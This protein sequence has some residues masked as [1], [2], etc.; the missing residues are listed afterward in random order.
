M[1]YTAPATLERE[2]IDAPPKFSANRTIEKLVAR[3]RE[4]GTATVR[5]REEDERHAVMVARLLMNELCEPVTV[6]RVDGGLRFTRE[7]A[8]KRRRT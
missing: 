5:C 4:V 7:W 2:A 3:L 6:S 8:A 1:S